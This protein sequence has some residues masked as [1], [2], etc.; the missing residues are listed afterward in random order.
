M[1]NCAR[2][3]FPTILCIRELPREERDLGS[4]GVTPVKNPLCVRGD[5][6]PFLD[7]KVNL[8]DVRAIFD[9]LRPFLTTQDPFWAFEGFRG[10]PA[11]LADKIS[12]RN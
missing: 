3:S 1:K 4:T 5:E 9:N 6:K 12:A 10:F 7:I 11:A 2:N 8:R